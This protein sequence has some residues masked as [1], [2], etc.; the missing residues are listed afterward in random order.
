MHFDSRSRQQRKSAD[1][2]ITFSFLTH[3]IWLIHWYVKLKIWMKLCLKGHSS[4]Y[5]MEGNKFTSQT[6]KS[7][8]L[9]ADQTPKHSIEVS[10]SRFVHLSSFILFFCIDKIG[11]FVN[12]N[13][14]SSSALE[15]KYVWVFG[16]DLTFRHTHGET[17][18]KAVVEETLQL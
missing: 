10:N 2:H 1:R 4:S 9:K 12:N 18:N 13:C 17:Q 6:M 15:K 3:L 5:H 14:Y 11:Q 7:M 16:L 8:S